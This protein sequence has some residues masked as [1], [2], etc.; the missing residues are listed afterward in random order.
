MEWL[1]GQVE[2]EV[3]LPPQL[4]RTIQLLH[5]DLDLTAVLDTAELAQPVSPGHTEQVPYIVIIIE[6]NPVSI[7]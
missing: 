5:T 2:A 7:N 4:A 3:V 6:V 1:N